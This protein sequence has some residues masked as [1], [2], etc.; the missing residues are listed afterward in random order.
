[1]TFQEITQLIDENHEGFDRFEGFIAKRNEVKGRICINDYIVFPIITKQSFDKSNPIEI[2]DENNTVFGELYF[3]NQATII[4]PENMPDALI[5]AYLIDVDRVDFQSDIKLKQDYLILKKDYLDD[6][7]TKFYETSGLWGGFIHKEKVTTSTPYLQQIQEIK[8]IP[9]LRYPTTWHQENNIRAIQQ[10]YAFE[11]FLKNYHQLE[12]LFDYHLVKEIQALGNDI[13]GA[14]KLLKEYGK[15]EEIQRLI[16]VVEK[17][18]KNITT[19]ETLLNKVT[20]YQTIAID[21][22]YTYGKV[23][24]N[25]LIISKEEH[26]NPQKLENILANGGIN[27]VNIAKYHTKQADYQKFLLKLACYWIYRVRSS[28][29]HAKIGEYQLSYT[30][31]KFVVEFAEPLLQEIIIQCF[32]N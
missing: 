11:R 3:S 21:I 25:P 30:D 23:D 14:G 19:I 8:L 26:T 13:Y 31:E 4:A 18:I 15:G 12:L 27:E 22:F 10:P 9:N 29:A 20:P 5:V 28:I 16:S 17:G 32:T 1:M 2:K 24:S 7:V 6:Y